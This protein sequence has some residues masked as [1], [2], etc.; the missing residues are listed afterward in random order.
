VDGE[1][2]IPAWQNPDQPPYVLELKEAAEHDIRRLVEKWHE[3]DRILKGKE[4]QA[5]KF[6]DEADQRKEKAKDELEKA[7]DAYRKAHDGNDPPAGTDARL[8]GYWLLL[9]FLFI[10]EFPALLHNS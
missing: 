1:K 8:L 10:F 4:E 9:A 5:Q 2:N 3:H 6:R 7:V